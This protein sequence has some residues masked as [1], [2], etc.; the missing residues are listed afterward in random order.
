M[1]KTF[2]LSLILSPKNLGLQQILIGIELGKEM[3][4]KLYKVFLGGGDFFFTFH[5]TSRYPQDILQTASIHIMMAHSRV[6]P[7]NSGYVGGI[8]PPQ[9]YDLRRS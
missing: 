3:G 7:L 5:G 9:R 8:S 6:S 2:K 1:L 4:T